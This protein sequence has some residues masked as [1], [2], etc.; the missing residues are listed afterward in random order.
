MPTFKAKSE[1]NISAANY[2]H[3]MKLYAPAVHCAY[4]SC[5]QLSKHFLNAK[6][7]DYKTQNLECGG[8]DS[9][10]YIIQETHKLLPEPL[11]Y[12]RDMNHLK[13]LRKKADYLNVKILIH[14]AND[15]LSTA[16]KTHKMLIP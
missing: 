10:N 16:K 4:Y 5:F 8:K 12:V 14:D 11:I 2:L 6:G 9:H 7:K 13:A 3:G 15:A 1:D